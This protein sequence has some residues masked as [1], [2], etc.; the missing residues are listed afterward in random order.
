[1]SGKIN[2]CLQFWEGDRARAMHLARFIAD[3]EP[4]KNPRVA[5]TFVAR[6][7]TQHD[8]KTVEYVSKKFDTYQ[9]TSRKPMTGWPAGC[10][11]LALELFAQSAERR[12]R[13]EWQDMKA[14]WLIE[15]D[16]MPLCRD[17]LSRISDEWDA[18][19]KKG[20]FILGAWCPWHGNGALGHINGNM[21]VSPDLYTLVP[22]LVNCPPKA[23]WDAYFSGKFEPHWEK[24]KSFANHYDYRSNIPADILW[25]K[26]DGVTEPVAVHGV[27]DFSAEQQVREKL[28]L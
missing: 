25:S 21:L 16:V 28:G 3:L 23:G 6:Y 8:Q 24:S 7:D 22:G 12:A 2:L 17:W 13:G 11:T 1:M 20:K 5:F 26:V 14:L 9:L 18:A 15:S 10:N 19:E 27:K 4:E